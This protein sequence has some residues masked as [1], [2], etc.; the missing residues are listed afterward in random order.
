[1]LI[2]H[3][4]FLYSYISVRHSFSSRTFSVPYIDLEEDFLNFVKMR[5]YGGA[6]LISRKTIK[7]FK[8]C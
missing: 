6:G 5:F 4:W 7:M 3:D 8:L 2:E 1:M